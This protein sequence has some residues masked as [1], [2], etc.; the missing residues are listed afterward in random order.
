MPIATQAA[1]VVV[2]TPAASRFAAPA[3]IPLIRGGNMQAKQ[4]AETR[5]APA[6]AAMARVMRDYFEQYRGRIDAVDAARAENQRRAPG[7]PKTPAPAP[8]PPLGLFA[9]VGLGK[10]QGVQA[11]AE[12]AYSKGLPV[13]ILVPT[14]EL[15]QPYFDQLHQFGDAVRVYQGRRAPG[16]EPGNPGAHA[17]Y[18]IDPVAIAGDMNHRPAQSL[19]KKCAHGASGVIKFVTRDQMRIQRAQ[20]L[21]KSYGLREQDVAPCQFLFKGLPDQMAAQIVIAPIQAFSE[22][23]ATW[24][25]VD[26]ETGFALRETQRLVLI[27]E[28][29]PLSKEV[30]IHGADVAGWRRRLGG[31]QDSLRDRAAAI[32]RK[33]E[34]TEDEQADFEKIRALHDMIPQIDHAFSELGA[35][36]AMDSLPGRRL[37]SELIDLHKRAAKLGGVVGGTAAWER[38]GFDAESN[39]FHIPL[40]ALSALADNLLQ[41][42][43]RAGGQ[44]DEDKACLFSYETSPV[45]EWAQEH[46]S[47]VFMD[48]TMGDDMQALIEKT[49]GYV[50]HASAAQNMRVTRYTG[51]LYARGDVRQAEEYRESAKARMTE[52]AQIAQGMGRPAA[53]I[54]HKAYLKYSADAWRTDEA[55]EQVAQGFQDETGVG[56]GWFGKHDRGLNIWSGHH[57]ALVGM[58][59]LSKAAIAGLYASTRNAMVNA[60]LGDQ[61]PVWDGIMDKEKPDAEG[62]PLPLMPSVRAWL[63]DTYAQGVAQAIGRN[64]AV[65]HDGEPLQVDFWGGIQSKEM[66]RVLL[67]YGITIHNRQLN[68]MSKT[69]PKP[70]EDAVQEAIDMILATG[71]RVSE[72][73]V[74]QALVGLQRKAS[75]QAIRDCLREM[76][77]AGAVPGAVRVRVNRGQDAPAT[78]PESPRGVQS[79]SVESLP[80]A[81]EIADSDPVE[82]QS[83]SQDQGTPLRGRE[84]QGQEKGSGGGVDAAAVAEPISLPLPLSST[85]PNSHKDHRKYWELGA[86]AT[87]AVAEPI[88][89]PLPLPSAVQGRE[90]IGEAVQ[91]G[92]ASDPA[93]AFDDWLESMMLQVAAEAEAACDSGGPQGQDSPDCRP[94]RITECEHGAG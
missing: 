6:R 75:N 14:H 33:G 64:R 11:I 38:I 42:T 35:A 94:S 18:Q 71:G 44:D 65:N 91:S 16:D 69:G 89:L 56:I 88:S 73:A 43:L 49:G 45:V 68:P 47:A 82:D 10:S 27:D 1:G 3:H 23:L 17:C 59:L 57:I 25:E 48:A 92:E 80:S 84:R 83:K 93:L 76:R 26:P 34:L 21:L 40:R 31:L 77:E 81:I 22:A 4:T 7:Q 62:P 13:L 85:A 46:G 30:P 39:E 61:W 37:S 54:T 36:I 70:D 74:R 8:L 52:L 2:S 28:H 55:A 66:D 29:I 60:G 72:R 5:N 90:R 24:R 15:A 41:G 20:D 63:M 32:E 78:P 86:V 9:T 19:C 79:E 53:I 87:D 50:Y 67:K 51:R 58:P 12:A